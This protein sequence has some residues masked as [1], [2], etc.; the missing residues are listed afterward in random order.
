MHDQP[1][2]KPLRASAFFADGRASRP[3]PEGTVARG[4]LDD[5]GPFFT[6]KANG[7]YVR[8]SP[9]ALTRPLLERGRE[10]YDIYC[11]PC[12]DRVGNGGGMIVQRGFRRPPSLHEE[13]LRQ[14]ALG[15]FF[16]I[17][18]NGFRVMPSYAQQVPVADRWAI[19]TY[20]RALQLSQ[21]ATLADVPAAERARLEQGKD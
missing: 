6:G 2:V 17:I 8:T 19:A 5:D 11:S 20:V 12:H 4:Q 18:G 10:R 21:T 13:R 9:V 15:Y 1:K 7:A 16:E 14:A 3:L